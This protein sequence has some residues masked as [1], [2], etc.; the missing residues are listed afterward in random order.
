MPKVFSHRTFILIGTL[1]FLVGCL[2]ITPPVLIWQ[3][4]K[5]LDQHFVL[6]QL[7]TYKDELTVYLPR[8]REIY[9]GN[10]PPR[11]L[12]FDEQRPTVLNPL[13]SALMAPFIF[14]FGGNINLAILAGQ[15]TFGAIIFLLFFFL[16]LDFFKSR[17]WAVLFSFMAV[18]TPLA[19]IFYRW[20]LDG[21]LWVSFKE[22]VTI[23]LK[24]FVPIINTPIHKLFLA[25]FDD[26]LLTYPVFLTAIFLFFRFWRNPV[27]KNA[28]LAAVPAALLFYTYFHYWVYWFTAVGVLFVWACFDSKERN[29]LRSFLWFGVVAVVIALPYFATYFNIKDFS[30]NKDYIYR[31][32]LAEGR[33]LDVIWQFKAHYPVYI[34]L[35]FLVS[36]F[37]SKR[38]RAKAILFQG[39]IGAMVIAGN[40]Q[41][42]VGFMPVPGQIAKPIALVIFI[43]VSILCHDVLKYWG[44]VGGAHSRI[45]AFFVFLSVLL[46]P[47]KKIINLIEVEKRFNE[48]AYDYSFPRDLVDSWQWINEQLPSDSK[49]ISPSLINSLYL[50]SYTSI[51]P[52]LPTGFA[53]TMPMPV[54]EERYLTANKLFGVDE[55]DISRKIGETEKACPGRCLKDEWFN[56]NKNLRFLYVNYF[57]SGDDVLAGEGGAPEEYKERLIDRVRSLNPDWQSIPAK[58]VYEGPWEKQLGSKSLNSFNNL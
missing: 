21:S 9:D 34:I 24:Q 37:Y 36:W 16:F 10:F 53:S 4:L 3:E 48:I 19:F 57:I 45:I 11:D 20:G 44:L 40:L 23:F 42:L 25:R 56:L 1:A 33:S 50:N 32:G 30:D 14:L 43:I 39:L 54:L 27:R 13:P 58:F 47:A 7:S 26:P 35:F 28:I 18:L 6:V 8:A 46:L 41:L 38:E 52:Y 31:F 5:N 29:R 15:F 17:V 55:E 12:Y 51:R 49:M 2:Y 22:I